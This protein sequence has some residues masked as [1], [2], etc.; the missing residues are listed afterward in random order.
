M[1][2]AVFGTGGAGGRFGAQLALAGHE[3]VFIAR[4]AHLAAIQADGL[5]VET[6]E[7]EMR[8]RPADATDTPSRVGAVDLVILGVKTWQ[9]A[10]AA[11]SMKPLIG[12]DTLVVPLQ[13]GVETPGQLVE[14]LGPDPVLG[15][16]CATFSWIAAPGVIRGIGDTHYIRFGEL[17]G[18]TSGR[19]ERLRQAFV[20]AGVQADVPESI[21]VALWK[22]FLT[23]VPFGGIG[24][25]TRAPA[26]VIRQVPQTR[27]MYSTGTREIFDVGRA[28]AI[29][30]EPDLPEKT[31]GFFDA[32]V[33]SGTTSLHR[34]IAAGKP[35]EL[36]AWVGAVVRLGREAKV[37]TPLHQFI[38]DA[39]LPLEMRARR[40]ID[41]E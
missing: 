35:S 8:V 13:N 18:R 12:P 9:V 30:L 20:E 39:L 38:Y 16:L 19:V 24:A 32:L 40:Q 11:R 1:R 27:A 29:A 26:G 15:G 7:G 37:P 3:V 2:I 10:D 33:P 23:V 4:G 41:F 22:K 17:D 28:R 31:M 36:E 14:I 21:Q 5:R 25:V 6:P 34:D